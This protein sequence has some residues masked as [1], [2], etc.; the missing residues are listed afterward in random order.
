MLAV[1]GAIL[2]LT[3][4]RSG[5]VAPVANQELPSATTHSPSQPGPG[6]ASKG[7]CVDRQFRVASTQPTQVRSGIDLTVRLLYTGKARCLISAYGP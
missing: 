7:F 4:C 5:G 1:A 6:N 3:G 2:N